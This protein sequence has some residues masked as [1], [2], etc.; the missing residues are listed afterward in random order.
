MAG[1]SCVFLGRHRL[2][3]LVYARSKIRKM[4]PEEYRLHP[5]AKGD[6]LCRFY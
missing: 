1:Y 6:L 5:L 3:L 2:N 4:I